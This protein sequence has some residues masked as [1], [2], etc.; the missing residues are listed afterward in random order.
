VE[1][2]FSDSFIFTC[3]HEIG[4][5]VDWAELHGLLLKL[6]DLDLHLT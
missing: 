1:P 3:Q 5:V 4:K 6:G 2:S